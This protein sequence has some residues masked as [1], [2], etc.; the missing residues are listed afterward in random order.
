MDVE[1]GLRQVYRDA[2]A[3]GL[4]EEGARAAMAVAVTEGGMGGAI[5]DRDRGRG[6]GGT[7]QLFF[8][9]QGFTGM[10]NALAQ[11]LGMDESELLEQLSANPHAFNS[12]VL[13]G[14]L[15]QAIREGQRRGLTGAALAEYAQRHGQRS[16]SPE[17][18]A[19]NYAL[20]A[21]TPVD[22]AG[23]TSGGHVH[24]AAEGP[25]HDATIGVDAIVAGG[26]IRHGYMD[27][28]YEAQLGEA[29]H[30]VD[31]A[32]DR[33]APV[34]TPVAGTVVYA[35]PDN[36]GA[37]GGIGVVVRTAD[38]HDV[39]FW[40][41]GGL[42]DGLRVGATVRPGDLLGQAGATGNARYVHTHFQVKDAQG[43][44][45]DPTPW[46]AGPAA[47]VARTPPFAGGEV[48]DQ[49]EMQHG[50][51]APRAPYTQEPGAPYPG[52]LPV[53]YSAGAA[54]P[55]GR[56]RAPEPELE[57]PPD[58]GGGLFGAAGRAIG[59]VADAVGGF[60][61]PRAQPEGTVL[62]RGRS[63]P[64][65]PDAATDPTAIA[66]GIRARMGRADDGGLLEA[67]EQLGGPQQI[68]FAIARALQ[69]QNPQATLKAQL[70]ALAGNAT[71]EQYPG[72]LPQGLPPLRF[73]EIL[74]GMGLPEGQARAILGR[75]GDFTL[76]PIN[77]TPLGV[78]SR[79][80]RAN[81][82]RRVAAEGL[83]TGAAGGV[84]SYALEKGAGAAV[85][86]LG[87]TPEQVQ[88]A[89]VAGNL[90]GGLG[91]G[92]AANVPFRGGRPARGGTSLADVTERGLERAEPL[93]REAADALAPGLTTTPTNPALVARAREVMP[94]KA[95]PQGTGF[96]TQDGTLLDVDGPG[97]GMHNEAAKLV[98]RN[99][100]GADDTP[101]GMYRSDQLMA[102]TGLVR[103]R[104]QTDP[105]SK[106][107][108]YLS[109]TIAR[110]MTSAQQAAVLRALPPNTPLYV[111]V[112]D[113]RNGQVLDLVRSEGGLADDTAVRRLL[114]QA[115]NVLNR[116]G[117]GLGVR[118][119]ED[120]APPF[121]SP[122][123]RAVESAFEKQPRMAPLQLLGVV[124]KTPGVKP[125]EIEWTDLERFILENA[126]RRDPATGKPL[127]LTK[128]EVLDHLDQ[129][130]VRVEEVMH[131][132][133]PG[134][135]SAAP[136][137]LQWRQ[138]D[139]Y[140]EYELRHGED[141]Y[142]IRQSEDDTPGY[143][144]FQ[145]DRYLDGGYR[146]P[147]AA[148]RVV[149]REWLGE[150]D[151]Q[152]RP[153]PKP[154]RW[155]RPDLNTPGGENYRELILTLPGKKVLP[156]WQK[157]E[158]GT[159]TLLTEHGTITV[160]P[161]GG[162]T[163]VLGSPRPWAVEYPAIRGYLPRVD[164][165]PD[166]VRARGAAEGF[167]SSRVLDE[168]RANTFTH[169]THWP[170]VEN[171]LA[172]VRFNDRVDA[173][174]KK[175]L[176]I[177]EVQ[178]DWHQAARPPKPGAEPVGYRPRPNSP[179]AK[180]A[181]R[182]RV[183]MSRLRNNADE[184]RNE[185]DDLLGG[186]L[187]RGWLSDGNLRR[188]GSIH[189]LLT[190]PMFGGVLSPEK[191]ELA[192]ARHA[193]WLAADK[194]H[195]DAL[196]QLRKL[197]GGPGAPPAAPFAR[198]GAWQELVMK[199]MIR[200]A[201]ENGYDRVA[202]TT[203]EMQAERYSA[204]MRN[205]QALEWRQLGP[206]NRQLMAYMQGGGTRSFPINTPGELQATVPREVIEQ[207]EASPEGG[208]I[209]GPITLG[210]EDKKALYDRMLPSIAKK[211]G[212]KFG[213]KVSQTS[214]QGATAS[215]KHR[216][217]TGEALELT[218][219]GRWGNG[220]IAVQFNS[221]Q[222]AANELGTD[223]YPITNGRVKLAFGSQAEAESYLRDFPRA[224]PGIDEEAEEGIVRAHASAKPGTK[225]HSLDITPAMR[226]SV[227]NQGQPLFAAAPP[228]VGSLGGL[229]EDEEGNL[230]YDPVRGAALAVGVGAVRRMGVKGQSLSV[231]ADMFTRAEQ[232]GNRIVY[233]YVRN[234][235]EAAELQRA[236]ASGD[237]VAGFRR[238]TV[239]DGHAL[240]T[241]APKIERAA[242]KGAKP[243]FTSPYPTVA[244]LYSQRM[245]SPALGDGGGNLFL[246]IEVPPDAVIYESSRAGRTQGSAYSAT[247]PDAEYVI[248]AN[249][250]VSVG[251]L[252]PEQVSL[253]ND[254]ATKFTSQVRGT[255]M[256]GAYKDSDPQL[257]GANLARSQRLEPPLDNL[258]RA[259][260][261]TPV[262]LPNGV[263]FKKGDR[264]VLRTGATG[265]V[266]G[267]QE[268][269]D[270]H[271]QYHGGASALLKL[272]TP[273]GPLPA[274][275]T[276]ADASTAAWNQRDT[277]V[278][279]VWDRATK[280]WVTVEDVKPVTSGKATTVV[281]EE[282]PHGAQGGQATATYGA[283]GGLAGLEEDEEGGIGFDPNKAAA[284]MAAG[285]VLGPR[286]GRYH[287]G[288]ATA[289]KVPDASKFDPNGLYGP[290]YYLT[291]DA[292][293]ASSYANERTNPDPS[294]LLKLQA[295]QGRKYNAERAFYRE[296]EK[297]PRGTEGYGGDPA[298]MPRSLAEKWNAVAK[299]LE[300]EHRAW[301][302][303]NAT[304]VGQQLRAVDLP[305]DLNVLDMDSPPV[306]TFDEVLVAKLPPEAQDV[307]RR[308]QPAPEGQLSFP[309]AQRALI[310][311]DSRF[312]KA[313][314]AWQSATRDVPEAELSAAYRDP[315][316]APL[317]DEWKAATAARRAAEKQLDAAR[318]RINSGGAR[319]GNEL[320]DGLRE[321]L[322][323][324][325][326][327]NE[328]LAMLGYDGIVHKG[329]KT[330][331]LL[332]DQGNPIEHDVV[333]VFPEALP[334]IK[335][336]ISGTPMG[337][338]APAAGGLAGVEE[339][340]EGGLGFD[341]NKAALGIGAGMAVGAVRNARANRGL[342]GMVEEP[343]VPDTPKGPS[344]LERIS[345]IRKAGMLSGVATQVFNNASN[346]VM[347]GADVGLKPVAAA[348][349][350]VMSKATGRNRSVYASEAVPQLVGVFGGGWNGGKK[351]LHI[352]KNG[353]EPDVAARMNA[354][355]R[356]FRS[357]SGK[358]D[359]A[360]EM[361]FRFLAA[362]DAI[363]RGAAEG[364]HAAALAHR[365]ATKEGLRGADRAKRAMEILDNLDKHPMIAA[366][367]ERE[368]IQ[369]TLMGLVGD[370]AE[371]YARLTG[372]ASTLEGIQTQ[373]KTM[374]RRSVFQEDREVIKG[375]QKF[376]Q[377]HEKTRFAVELL[378]PFI[379]TPF[380]VV[381]QGAEFTPYGFMAAMD[382]AKKGDHS[383]EAELATRGLVG[384][385]IGAI[386][387]MAAAAGYLTGAYPEDEVERTTLPEGWKPFS[388]RVPSG[389][390]A[391]YVP[392]AALGAFSL[393]LG[394]GAVF[395]D[396]YKQ[397]VEI[398]D[399][400]KVAW[401]AFGAVAT[402]AGEQTFLQGMR[403]VS[404]I[405]FGDAERYGPQTLEK[406]A[407]SFAPYGALARQ[408]D[409]LA[410]Q[411]LRDPEG[412]I[413]ALI[414]SVPV[415]NQRV[416]ARLTAMGDERRP[417]VQGPAALL[418]GNRI[419]VEQRDPTLAAMRENRVG[420]PKPGREA[421]GIGLTSAEEREVQRLT[422][423]YLRESGVRVQEAAAYKS[424]N[425]TKRGAILEA[426]RDAARERARADVIRNMAPE[427]RRRRA[428]V[429]A[430][431]EGKRRPAPRIN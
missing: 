303:M 430:E 119:T 100:D 68:S 196:A 211:L 124:K 415:A 374:A 404:E 174:G 95:N 250:V 275:R 352:L 104:M 220:G 304:R 266:T 301:E 296:Q 48:Y 187:S 257:A 84:G 16:E 73:E 24:E 316:Y 172:H 403:M 252:S 288:T 39:S 146:T 287:H 194:A 306:D 126:S 226:G 123:R 179:E 308:A 337:G 239:V 379:A 274:H 162:R 62:A 385:G 203:G 76:D 300:A 360:V 170:G 343:E 406:L 153:V 311:A 395:A 351:F 78:A 309:D 356:G 87:G 11:E 186:G 102:E 336:A 282:P 131:G 229:E 59:G 74:A 207:I 65:N 217:R 61:R 213:A 206:G 23:T 159:L 110:P 420:L 25:E 270:V 26:T 138:V 388:L 399:P 141:V 31:I 167:W 183:D 81:T 155:S 10:G 157:Q 5:G 426:V 137:Q 346:A 380:N 313:V 235:E 407:G 423:K 19:Q 142:L 285:M 171:P 292:R 71:R 50:A 237:P 321:V 7:F 67:L 427:E 324:K 269:Q 166:E 53:G 302:A 154:T 4:D 120:V 156:P 12:W 90:V 69:S 408:L 254:H 56:G 134:G 261:E 88:T 231:D 258:G 289:F 396:A 135:E 290:G 409:Q 277:D 148:Q 281:R 219:D 233:R 279:G 93:V 329:G 60:L 361:P 230:G 291:R 422:G 150:E 232:A 368:A 202:W 375:L 377:E 129:N 312:Q 121:F 294:L 55:L 111:E 195:E 145:N 431:A 354:P 387:F 381:A 218:R 251:V 227:M 429:K 273:R 192:R 118:P 22:D 127:P 327:A 117:L 35:G 392:I 249:K 416:P 1:E 36:S 89:R 247:F 317:M 280:K 214:L 355:E 113:P 180:E 283:A 77:F 424:G 236:L 128:Q 190:D 268:L 263:Q 278:V 393:P 310:E 228:V 49:P 259:F 200:W 402:Y 255:G 169:E 105:A 42:G 33:G 143:V 106:A 383:R 413:D 410:G 243:V 320:Y 342:T 372:E 165:Y 298:K 125:E 267:Y 265:Y 305:E 276:D 398:K 107:G 400:V 331:P 164:T 238:T 32:S 347:T 359:A 91:G 333:V 318:D 151:M 75:I 52:A 366:T 330:R 176:F 212:D 130:E 115:N 417:G 357:G 394:I 86:A 240:S 116:S 21:A 98:Y 122:V 40:H 260:V 43:N 44:Y 338:Y 348:Y 328:A 286:A 307:V 323:S 297:W 72:Q 224:M 158:D 96:L 414:A 152:G 14:Y 242:A 222:E 46:L 163:D 101:V 370:S 419:G 299:A 94:V 85:E 181:A 114:G 253:V 405:V 319:D 245:A 133:P 188:E 382:A 18:A 334:K 147:E 51:P 201:A 373:A 191:A 199:R 295:A 79:V 293:V 248:D 193:E 216:L 20:A 3:A 205:V 185:I 144:I 314:D 391:V 178:S 112:V 66:G 386:A 397:G 139:M 210:G 221:L 9:P 63:V 34:T 92:I 2:I 168:K 362:F 340:E 350:A 246:A 234:P 367:A 344:N 82:V 189:R 223:L 371:E 349:D 326:K 364:G 15:G 28:D 339:D 358:V 97:R 284:G 173:D 208:R 271:K 149:E 80:G 109:L 353:V 363:W 418:L 369:R 70:E 272:S 99:V 341:P 47:D 64:A 262:E 8:G 182:L 45:V 209:E 160:H 103:W 38:G 384:T 428:M 389:D 315:R 30:G 241:K 57:P 322:G 376:L 204:L 161:P 17:R 390:G 108:T 365:Q 325:A 58:N 401:R 27:P 140:D 132:P 332:D 197:E 136:G 13:N 264:V 425:L 345:T 184:L 41:L 256:R 421:L 83:A 198:S 378:V 215:G 29:H 175:V 37:N 411:P 177:E 412:V 54:A 225:V 244:H 6:S 335:N